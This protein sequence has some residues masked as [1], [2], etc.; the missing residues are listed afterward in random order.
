MDVNKFGESLVKAGKLNLLGHP[1]LISFIKWFQRSYDHVINPLLGCLFALPNSVT[2]VHEF[3]Q[4]MT[5]IVALGEGT[6]SVQF[7]SSVYSVTTGLSFEENNEKNEENAAKKGV[8]LL[9]QYFKSADVAKQRDI[10]AVLTK[11]LVNTAISKVYFLNEEEFDFSGFPNA[12][13]IKQYIISTRL[14]FRDA[15]LFC[16]QYLVNSTVILANADIYFDETLLRLEPI[17]HPLTLQPAPNSGGS[18]GTVM[19][20]LKWVH[21]IGYGND[22]DILSLSLRTDSQDAWVFQPPLIRDLALKADF[23][24]GLPR[25]DNRLAW[26]LAEFNYTV[27]N[28]ALAIHAI[29]MDS[30]PRTQALYGMKNSVNG[31]G[32]NVFL[33]DL[34]NFE[35]Q[36]IT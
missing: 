9:L 15:F 26:L 20:L 4:Q 22:S 14:T 36:N 13:K 28:P 27:I 3:V 5:D 21:H 24:M 12:F 33:S 19:A 17:V 31:D 16:N 34:F 29:E 25:C 6:N 30:T 2:G 18:S 11:N 32:K 8:V 23:S 1:D 10:D 35:K 7:L